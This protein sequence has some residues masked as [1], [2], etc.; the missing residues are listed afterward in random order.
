MHKF[1]KNSQ[2]FTSILIFFSLLDYINAEICKLNNVEVE[3]CGDFYC[4]GNCTSLYCCSYAKLRFNQTI[5]RFSSPTPRLLTSSTT[6]SGQYD[7]SFFFSIWFWIIIFFLIFP[8]MICL[9]ICKA[10]IQKKFEFNTTNN[11]VNTFYN[12]PN[13]NA[14]PNTGI[15]FDELYQHDD[16]PPSYST[17]NLKINSTALVYPVKRKEQDS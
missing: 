7:E 9:A 5:C 13:S 8:L 15:N 6:S 11:N 17:L 14:S 1:I 12:F 4:C 3:N 10:L 16:L 2:V